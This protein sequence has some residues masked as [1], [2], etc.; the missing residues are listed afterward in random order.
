MKKL[1]L[2]DLIFYMALPFLLW[3]YGREPFGDYYAMLLSTIPGLVYTIYRFYRE[4]Q[5]NIS[6][7]FIIFSLFLS[8]TVNV[9]S[10][11]AERLLWNQVY[12]G[13]GYAVIYGLSV[14]FRKPFAL[15]FA[16]D[17][18]YLQ[19]YP[20]KNSTMLFSSKG[21]FVWYQLLT[22]LI[23]IRGI[24][25]S[26]LKAW[27]LNKYGV[28]GYG[29]M[30]VYMQISG[31]IFG[32][33]ITGGYFLIGSITKRYVRKHYGEDVSMEPPIGVNE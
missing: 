6:G 18:M 3:N 8:T 22:I 32:G 11:D 7:L 28:D 29:Q 25:Q 30:L 17:F 33:L 4:R 20:R 31:W 10:G 19:G 16:V 24:F 26:S 1:I 2:F 13:Y 15:F 5:F 14:L 27:L 12:L 9:L 23:C 21:I